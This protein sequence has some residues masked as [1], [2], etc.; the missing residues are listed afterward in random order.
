MI[1]EIQRRGEQLAETGQFVG[2]PPELFGRVGRDQLITALANG[3]TPEDRL[4]ELGCC[5]LRGGYWLMHFLNPGNY[6]GIEPIEHR[7]G[8]GV[9]HILGEGDF[10][11]LQPRFAFNENFDASSF[12]H[13]FEFILGR[14]VWTHCSKSQIDVSLE[15]FKSCAAPGGVMLMTIGRAD[16]DSEDYKG[17]GWSPYIIKHKEDWLLELADL[18]DLRVE[19]ADSPTDF[20]ENQN[21]V[22]VTRKSAEGS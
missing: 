5:V 21:W 18:K 1:D 2:G 22:K 12:G 17:D 4:L 16:N 9:E 19:R 14:S 20:V 8:L 10:E 7:P 13:E 6:C 3:L 15:S 11:R